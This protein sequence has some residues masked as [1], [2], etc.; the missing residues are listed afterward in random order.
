MKQ[1]YLIVVVLVA[2][3]LYS[4]A[5]AT[6]I[7]IVNRD[8]VNEGLNSTRPVAPVAGNSATTLGQ[9]Y[10]NVFEAAAKYW[11]RKL[12]SDVPIRVDVQLDPLDCQ[13]TFGTLGSA[14]PINGF[15]DFPNAPREET[16]Y[17]VAQANS[18]AGVDLDPGNSDIN[19]TFNNNIG[20]SGCLTGLSWWLGINSPAPSGTISFYDTILHEIGHGLGFLSLVSQDGVR[21]ANLNDTYMLNLFDVNQNLPWSRMSDRQRA[22]S[23]VNSQGLVWS[24]PN[25]AQGAG[26]FTG[27][28]NNS[29]LRMYSPNPFQPGS[30]VSHWDTVVSPDELMEPFATQTSDSC[31]TILALKDMGW[32]TRNECVNGVVPIAPI[33]LLLD[34]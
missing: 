16:I 26:V 17:V 24:G 21:L 27:G 23:S 19:A 28:R 7:D 5:G 34:E 13:P 3:V 32:R 20:T 11:E 18:L 12:V 15:I 2:S 8:G 4:N 25:V 29:M 9:Q 31:A 14:G 33:F 30:S 10:R 22:F 6:D 1:I